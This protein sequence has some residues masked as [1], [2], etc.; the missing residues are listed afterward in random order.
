MSIINYFMPLALMQFN[1]LSQFCA[2]E[3]LETLRY[4]RNCSGIAYKHLGQEMS[5]VFA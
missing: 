2:R 3:A 5:E 1:Q 4:Q